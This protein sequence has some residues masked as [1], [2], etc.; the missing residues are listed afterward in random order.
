MP[1]IN[2]TV[3]SYN[4]EAVAH[5]ASLAFGP[6]GK[7]LGRGKDNHLVL[8]DPKNLVSR[9]H[10]RIKSDGFRHSIVNMSQHNP[11]LVNNCE[12]EPDR[13]YDLHVG[14]EIRIGLYVLRAEAHRHAGPSLAVSN[15]T[16][17]SSV[18]EPALAMEASAVISNEAKAALDAIRSA[19]IVG[20]VSM[21]QARS[22]APEA[23]EAAPV[24]ESHQALLDAFL[25]GAG[26]PS[27][28][29]AQGLTPELMET[30]GKLLAISIKGTMDLNAQ[31]AFV[32]REVNADVTMVVVRNNNPLKFL[33][34]S[35][36]V[37]TQMFRKKM[38]GFMT[39]T[40]ALQ[41]IYDDLRAHQAGIMAGMRA[42]INN[43][44]KRYDPEALEQAVTNRSV[45]DALMP[46][47]RKAKLWDTFIASFKKLHVKTQEDFH[48]IFGKPFLKAYEEEV[49]RH[50]NQG[51]HV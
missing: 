25:K 36:T 13:E 26:I 22:A 28:T 24:N 39:P 41:D 14:D 44:L 12:I 37:L 40:E 10:A 51:K 6:E 16:P 21:N 34:D 17:V 3:V 33:S 29:V 1:M 7:T 50:E 8:E 46:T 45:I 2:I 35:E 4:N 23:P 43:A 20:G 9:I 19:S 5:P 38:P 18:A 47:R 49:E 27:V 48:A 42:A 11:I 30:L 15:G 32:K 31:R